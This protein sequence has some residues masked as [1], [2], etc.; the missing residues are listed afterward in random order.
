MDEVIFVDGKDF[1]V[2]LS[3]KYTK[4]DTGLFILAPSGTGKSH[5]CKN[6]TEN[7]WIDGDSLW[8]DSG[9]HPDYDWWNKSIEV[10]NRIDS[11]SDVIT[12]QAIIH[13]FW[14]MGASNLWLKP[15][16]IVIPDW[17]THLNYIKNRQLNNYDGGATLEKLDQLKSHIKTIEEWNKSHKVPMFKSVDEAVNALTK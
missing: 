7:N 5:Y 11:R 9:A 6:Q 15:S 13:G 14:I 8:V 1:F 2:E 4:H 10:I 12:E 16:A 3:K 17:E